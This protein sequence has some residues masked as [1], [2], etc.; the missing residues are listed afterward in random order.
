MHHNKNYRVLILILHYP[1]SKSYSRSYIRSQSYKIIGP[2]MFHILS[3][4]CKIWDRVLI[5][6]DKIVIRYGIR[7]MQVLNRYH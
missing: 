7:I 1:A 5:R 4:T 2:K 6:F 3:R